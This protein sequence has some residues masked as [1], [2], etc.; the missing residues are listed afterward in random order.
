[1]KKICIIIITIFIAS[2]FITGCSKSDSASS[3]ES[4]NFNKDES[5]ALGMNLGIGIRESLGMDGIYPNINE[6]VKGFSDGIKG[7]KTRFNNEQAIELIDTAFY[8]LSEG[9]NEEAAQI[10]RT[11]MAENA[12]KPGIQ[13]TLSG[14]QYE[15]ISETQG[16]KPGVNSTVK[17]HY[18]GR[19]I[20]GSV[21]DSS[22][23]YGE[24]VDFPI[25]GVIP[26][27]T[28]GLQ[29][30]SAGSIYI[31][32]VPSEL[33][34]GSRGWMSIPPHAPLIFKVE[35]LEIMD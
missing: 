33:G 1:M 29:L 26:G 18:E 27:W 19:L 22:Y 23:Q 31:F 12:R 3:S 11:F 20:D 13:V 4:T 25:T 35:L 5:Y 15:I 6:L 32:Y 14:L 16:P 7:E 10:E 34:Y 21:F 17:V 28:E 9:K 24:P 2:V 30:M 8:S